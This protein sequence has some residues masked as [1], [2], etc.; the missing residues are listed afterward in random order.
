MLRAAAPI[1][2]LTILVCATSPTPPLLAADDGRVALAESRY[3]TFYSDFAFNLYDALLSAATARTAH[4]T[5][6]LEDA[7]SGACFDRLPR[8]QRSAWHEAVDYFATNVAATYTFSRERFAFRSHLA[9]LMIDDLDDDDGEDLRLGLLFMQAAEA[10]YRTCRWPAQAAANKT[11]IEQLL[12]KLE[13]HEQAIGERLQDRFGQRWRQLPIAVDVVET[14]GRNGADTIAGP[15]TH[16]QINSRDL[17]YQ[18][19]A[20]LELIFHEISHEFVGPRNGPI[21]EALAAAAR[22]VQ[23]SVP[24]DLWHGVLFVTV[25]EV[26]RARLAEQGEVEE[27]LPSAE[28][29][30][31][32]EGRW[33]PLYEPL[34]ATWLPYVQ[35]SGDRRSAALDLL[36]ALE[37]R[38]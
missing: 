22:T 10:A 36:R 4:R 31:V 6:D 26:T 24:R 5:E 12:P 7:E 14:A 3:F 21:A 27:Y 30:G 34:R 1:F 28:S 20:S 2:V 17:G 29:L 23:T 18:G 32:F 25:G 33:R 19:W 35:G 13:Q 16:T 38:P 9:Q 37:S 15:T 11:W 8:E